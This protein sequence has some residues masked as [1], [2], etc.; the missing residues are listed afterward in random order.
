[1]LRSFLMLLSVLPCT[2]FSVAET[3][4]TKDS[5]SPA[6]SRQAP[7]SL[8]A[9]GTPEKQKTKS[10]SSDITLEERSSGSTKESS[11]STGTDSVEKFG[12]RE[13]SDFFN[14]RE[15]NPQVDK[16]EWEFE[17]ETKWFTRSNGERDE[18]GIAQT[19]KYG[20]TDDFFIELEEE[21]GHLGDGADQGNGDLFI[22]LF[23]RFIREDETVPAVAAQVEMRLPTG[24]GS[25]GIDAA[26]SLITTKSITDRLR[27]HL[28]GIIE[29]ANGGSGEE[30]I[31]RRHFQWAI[32]PGID[33]QFDERTLGLLN[34]IN[35]SS[36]E[37]GE[38]NENLLEFGVVHEIYHNGDIHSHIKLAADVGLDGQDETPNFGTK[39]QW[40]IDW[41]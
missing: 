37:Y 5:R 9:Y 18:I 35:R 26:L 15:A 27:V 11:E 38:H 8:A 20:V 28:E 14:I 39:F 31:N 29:T 40:S 2:T 6:V 30:D 24:D 41:K 25:S 16:G 3:P 10:A 23:N 32:G 7:L 1:M 13:V 33:Y 22:V 12:Y 4:S 19:L 34:Y 17:F 21:Q 36:E